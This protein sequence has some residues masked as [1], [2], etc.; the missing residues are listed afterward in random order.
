MEKYIKNS[1]EINA[2]KEAVWAALIE[3]DKTKQYMFGCE[4]ISNWQPGSPLLWRGNY[5]GKEMDFV[6]GNIVSIEPNQELSYTVFDPN[7]TM[8]D[9]PENYLTVAYNLKEEDNKTLLSVSQG[10]FTTVAEGE[11]RYTEIFNNGEGWQPILVEIK[12]LVENG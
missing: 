4:A 7:G 8:E 6:I 11:K 1:I 3:P 10:D 5:E 9:V 12:K 2:S